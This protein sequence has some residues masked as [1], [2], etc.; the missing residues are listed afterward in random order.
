LKHRLAA[1]FD[2]LITV[3]H[4]RAAWFFKYAA[5]ALDSLAITDL[6]AEWV[7]RCS[8]EPTGK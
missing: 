8:D 2:S 6:R 7:S 5:L 1:V 4:L 3:D